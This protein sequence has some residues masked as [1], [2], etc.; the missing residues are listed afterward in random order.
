MAYLAISLW[1]IRDVA[2]RAAHLADVPVARPGRA[3]SAHYGGAIIT[4]VAAVVTLVGAVLLVRSAARSRS[5]GRPAT[6]AA[7]ARSR[8][9]T[10]AATV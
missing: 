8:R 6:S 1:V 10:A 9:S 7:G 2:V 3:R 5:R 4:L